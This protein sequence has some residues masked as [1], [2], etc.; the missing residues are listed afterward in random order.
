MLHD[1][2]TCV[3]NTLVVLVL[4]L[5]IKCVHSILT[6]V[7]TS[8]QVKESKEKSMSML[9]HYRMAGSND[10]LHDRNGNSQEAVESGSLSFVSLLEFVSEIYQVS[11]N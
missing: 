8:S 3:F 5:I 6:V 4:F 1:S 11:L 10:F 7:C 2:L 9:S